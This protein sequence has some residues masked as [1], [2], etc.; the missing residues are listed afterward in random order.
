MSDV[1]IT[2]TLFF[3][4][5][6]S[7]LSYHV[8]VFSPLEAF[9]CWLFFP[10]LFSLKLSALFKVLWLLAEISLEKHFNVVLGN[11]ASDSVLVH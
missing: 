11:W 9:G 2:W 8:G 3:H 5:F 10:F 1:K 7:L 4:S 6:F